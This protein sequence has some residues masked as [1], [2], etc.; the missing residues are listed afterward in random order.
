M[1]K[2]VLHHAS[3]KEECL[4]L[5]DEIQKGIEQYARFDHP[6][7]GDMYVYE[8]DGEG[9]INLMDDANVPSLLAAP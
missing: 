4:Q 1:C 6:I 5:R 3:L 2:E 7:Y 8:T 9:R